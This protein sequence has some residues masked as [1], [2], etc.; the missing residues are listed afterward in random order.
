MWGFGEVIKDI[1]GIK[2]NDYHN[3][4]NNNDKVDDSN[5]DDNYDKGISALGFD[6]HMGLL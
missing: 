6:R 5:K 2:D 4:D 1:K 3:N